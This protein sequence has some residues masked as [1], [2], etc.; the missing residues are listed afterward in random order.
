MKNQATLP[1]NQ[2]QTMKILS[3]SNAFIEPDIRKA[4]FIFPTGKTYTLDFDKNIQMMELK[5]MIQKAAHLRK[6]SFIL[7]SECVNITKYNEETFDSLFPDKQL[8]SFEVYNYEE[9]PDEIIELLLQINKPCP[10]HD[11]KCL[12]YY[13]FDCGKSICSQCC[14]NEIHKGHRIQDKSFYLLPS[15]YLADK[16]FENWSKKPYED[17]KISASLYEYKARLNDKIFSELFQLLKEVQN[18]CN[19]LIDKYNQINESSL[20]NIRDSVR[21]IELYCIRALD[22]YKNA[23]DIKDIINSEEMFI[24]FD[25]TYKKLASQQKEKFR[26]NIQK[27]KD[28]NKSISLLVQNLIDK[29][30]KNIKDNLLA[31]LNQKEY[32]NIENKI[33]MKLIKPLDKVQ[34]MNQISDKKNKIKN[35][36]YER[37]SISNY[38]AIKNNIFGNNFDLN[39]NNINNN[40]TAKGRHTLTMEFQPNINNNKHSFDKNSNDNMMDLVSDSYDSSVNNNVDNNLASNGR[41]NRLHSFN[42]KNR[43]NTNSNINNNLNVNNIN[44]NIF[45]NINNTQ[46]LSN[47]KNKPQP[48]KKAIKITSETSGPSTFNNNIKIE[49]PKITIP[50]EYNQTIFTNIQNMDNNNQK[51]SNLIN[52]HNVFSSVINNK[53]ENKDKSNIFNNDSNINYFDNNSNK[54]MPNTMNMNSVNEISPII[55]NR[56]DNQGNFNQ[57]NNSSFN[58]DINNLNAATLINKEK[59]EISNP[60]FTENIIGKNNSKNKNIF[61]D[62]AY[63]NNNNKNIKINTYPTQVSSN[64]TLTSPFL[65]N[66]NNNSTTVNITTATNNDNELNVKKYTNDNINIE[67]T[68]KGMFQNNININYSSNNDININ[69]INKTQINPFM[70]QNNKTDFVSVIAN[71]INESKNELENNQYNNNLIRNNFNTIQEEAIE[72]DSELKHKNKEIK[73]IDIEAYLKKPFILCP[74]PG[75]NKIKIIT[76]DENDESFI[77]IKFPEELGIS[78]FLKNCSYCNY[79]K[80][81]YI[82]GGYIENNNNII[83]SKKVF[84][85]DLFKFNI[86][87]NN[88]SIISELSPMKYPKYNHSMIGYNGKIY[89]VGGENSDIVERYDINTNNWEQLNHMIKNRS[90]PN[91][92]IYEGYL[93]AFFGK[94]G[95][96]YL[97]NIERLNLDEMSWTISWELVVFENPNEVDTRIYG[98]GLYQV[99]ELIYFFGGKKMDQD[100][101]EIFFINMKERLIDRSDDK[102]K[103]KESFRENTLFQ[104]GNKIVQISDEKYFGTY[105]IAVVQ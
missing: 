7:V 81:L 87:G 18:K 16:M 64:I 80:K 33:N 27:F 84:V 63:N 70:N 104:L 47:S 69:Q 72:S 40:E 32:E 20:N 103:W 58:H 93:Y 65:N 41:S 48:S 9:R 3:D 60:F 83:P 52:I 86:E 25:N 51:D 74:I 68:P 55:E 73:N 105:L 24:E 6:D 94:E 14:I 99:D 45:N 38:K 100:T 59:A 102:L 29:I 10:D 95:D 79:D 62:N 54:K 15:K 53:N 96:E 90:F 5:T 46:V 19:G 21:D 101:D 37:R 42:D 88:N 31:V 56:A 8:V 2:D 43:D 50:E 92:Y 26:E 36:K 89:S 75:T 11:Y 34:I 67:E 30:C 61:D 78:C 71:K 13:C 22:E 12:L 23:K 35:K 66:K 76:N 4:K 1:P 85:I 17:F 44:N 97:K 28:L 49:P 91:L 82:S 57:S 77:N 98:C 39:N